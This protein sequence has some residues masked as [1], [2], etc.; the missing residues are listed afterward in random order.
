MAIKRASF[1]LPAESV[2]SLAYVSRR[3]GVSRSSLV[4]QMLS[5]ALPMMEKML[6]TVPE[7]GFSDEAE[8]RRF[9]GESADV[10]RQRIGN[11]HGMADDLF[12]PSDGG[13][14]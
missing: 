5:E 11:L 2:E 12:A 10:I 1:S 7:G 8:T 6:R 14:S 13:G 4:S 9:R 3:L